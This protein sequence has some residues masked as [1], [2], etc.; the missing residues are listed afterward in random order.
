MNTISHK[1]PM[2]ILQFSRQRS[3]DGLPVTS[4]NHKKRA[5]DI[6]WLLKKIKKL[7]LKMK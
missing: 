1:K 3:R 4:Q 6:K 7:F 2:C 5:V